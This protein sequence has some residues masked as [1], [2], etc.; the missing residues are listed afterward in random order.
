MN[1][2]AVVCATGVKPARL[3][4]EGAERAVNAKEILKG[5]AA[6]KNT[7][8]IGGGSIGCETAEYLAAKGK[9]VTIIEMQDTLAGNTGKTAQ[10]V[11]LGHLKG[12]GVKL[13]TGCRVEK[14]TADSVIYKDKNGNSASVKAD[15]VVL[16]IGDKP[17]A[18]LYEQLK[19]KVPEIYN[20]G[21]SN[22]GGIIPTA[23]YEGYTTG[24]LI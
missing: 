5:K 8:V 12:H 4:I 1:A 7:V 6:E 19:D 21:D 9:K 11:L 13:L 3:P 16:A 24:N 17:D 20:I 2:D 10:T 14:I 15:T 18:S 22:G 23:V